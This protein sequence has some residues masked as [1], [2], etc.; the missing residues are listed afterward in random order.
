MDSD[1]AGNIILLSTAAHPSLSPSPSGITQDLPLP[2]QLY[3]KAASG[4]L[5]TIQESGREPGTGHGVWNS[6]FK[7]TTHVVLCTNKNS[8]ILSS[9]MQTAWCPRQSLH[10]SFLQIQTPWTSH[11]ALSA[12]KVPDRCLPDAKDGH[13]EPKHSCAWLKLSV[14]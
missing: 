13:H 7:P 11:F 9:H 10:F 8:C 4:C 5:T 3:Q 6:S 1:R 2:P 12:C 14:W